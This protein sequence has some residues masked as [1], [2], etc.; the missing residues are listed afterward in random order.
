MTR[1]FEAK[2]AVRSQVPLLVGLYGASGSGK[3]Y[4]A[5]R[6]ATGVQSVVGGDIYFIDTEAKRGLH[7]ADL[8]KFKHVEFNAPFSSRDYL[9]AI[10][11]C[12]KQ[13]AK[14]IVI[15]SMSHEHSGEGGYLD[16][17][18]KEV[19]RMSRGDAAKAERVKMA[20]WIKPA[21]DRRALI[22]GILQINT[23]LIAC[24]RAKEKTKPVKGG[25]IQEL[26]FMPIAGEEFVF[27]MTVN[28]LL[29][30]HAGGVPT[31]RSDQVGER[32]MLKLPEQFRG[33]FRD[34]KP[35]DEATG[36]ALAEWARGGAASD[37]PQ[38]PR[39]APPAASRGSDAP[40]QPEATQGAPSPPTQTV[41]ERVSNAC[42]AMAKTA[43]A[44]ALE[45]LW[46]GAPMSRLKA[47]V[48]GDDEL[49]EILHGA[50]RDK[51]AS[52]TQPPAEADGE[53]PY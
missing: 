23:N 14:V 12:H 24:F 17:H 1:T 21:S 52:F 9:E 27:E 26:G 39:S 18:E 31:W 22:D 40:T 6:L 36:A 10:R 43:D 35:L 11:W 4:S 48:E 37:A 8:F 38:S 50:Y 49:R 33:L 29:M 19:E 32:M 47:A 3:T 34:A 15:D 51:A 41:R 42:L 2:P 20:G 16:A 5:L 13:G 28:A 25:G 44:G 7:Y 30:P 45:N 53:I 46:S